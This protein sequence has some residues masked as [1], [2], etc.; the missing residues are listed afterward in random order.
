[1]LV[2]CL[3][4]MH[5]SLKQLF[6]MSHLITF[7]HCACSAFID[8]RNHTRNLKSRN[9]LQFLKFYIVNTWNERIL[10]YDMTIDNIFL[11]NDLNFLVGLIEQSFYLFFVWVLRQIK[12]ICGWNT[13]HSEFFLWL[14]NLKFQ[15][16]LWNKR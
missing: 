7:I 13:I 5:F 4:N 2:E 15:Q 1:M 10:L 14:N 11:V 8:I 9:L 3:K 12:I 6:Q 16:Q